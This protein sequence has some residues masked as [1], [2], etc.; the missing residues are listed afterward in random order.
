MV[1]TEARSFCS[2][3]VFGLL[4]YC[5][6]SE[7]TPR[8]RDAEKRKRCPSGFAWSRIYLTTGRNPISAIW[9][10]SS[11]A[12]I[13]S[14][15]SCTSTLSRRSIRRPGVAT[16]IA[17]ALR[18]TVICLAYGIPP[19]ITIDSWPIA[20]ARG[21]RTSSICWASSRVGVRTSPKGLCGFAC[22]PLTFVLTFCQ[23]QSQKVS[24]E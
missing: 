2:E 9:S 20:R 18:I 15:S 19:S 13:W 3:C 5:L 10:A 23:N 11:Q 21:R 22:S 24:I 6:T 16:K 8:S 7:S 1:D 17:V 12:V 4:R 14:W